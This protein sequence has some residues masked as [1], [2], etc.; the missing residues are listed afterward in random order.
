MLLENILT[1]QSFKEHIN[2][3]R[4]FCLYIESDAVDDSISFLHQVQRQLL[5][6]YTT[7]LDLPDVNST[8]RSDLDIDLS[9]EKMDK[10]LKVISSKVPFSY[11][12]TVLNPVDN[13]DM[14]ETGTGDLI[15]DL[16]DIY[17]DLKRSLLLFDCDDAAAKENAVYKLKFYYDNHWGEH[18]IDA[19]QVIHQYLF[20]NR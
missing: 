13:V 5:V 4:V 10:I 7:G 12:W 2:A 6:L 16:A 1:L 8:S 17:Y 19:L 9:K 11:Y 14:A 18:C 3:A 15:D 20:E